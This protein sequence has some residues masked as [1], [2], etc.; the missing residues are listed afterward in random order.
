LAI[1]QSKIEGL[2]FHTHF[3]YALIM[4]G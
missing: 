4:H 3:D 2:A 1:F